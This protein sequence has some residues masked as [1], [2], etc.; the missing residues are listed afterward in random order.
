MWVVA[1]PT[2][3]VIASSPSIFQRPFSPSERRLRTLRKSSANP[4]AAHASVAS[5]TVSPG[6]V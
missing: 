1:H 4:I 6:H 3:A 5:S 2:P